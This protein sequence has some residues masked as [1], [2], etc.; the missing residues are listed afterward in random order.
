[1]L[2]VGAGPVGLGLGLAAQAAGIALQGVW[3]RSARA[4][5]DFIVH[6]FPRADLTVLAVRDEVVAALATRLPGPLVH[7]AGHLSL[8]EATLMHPMCA[9]SDAQQAARDLPRAR[10]TIVGAHAELARHFVQRLGAHA[11][12][13][14]QLDS[15]RYHA[16]CVMAANHVRKLVDLAAAEAASAGLHEARAALSSLA[17]QA[18]TTELTGPAQR[19]NIGVAGKHL[20]ALGG[21]AADAYRLLSRA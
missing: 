5:Y 20:A 1:V 4:G 12:V 17:R 19:G 3:S 16:A 13:H 8:P 21:C 10:F 7:T 2:I 9:C 18:L 14:S 11:E 6:D 15:A